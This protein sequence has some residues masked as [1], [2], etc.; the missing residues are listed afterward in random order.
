M[1]YELTVVGGDELCQRG[2]E[3]MIS[4]RHP[5]ILQCSTF[6]SCLAFSSVVSRATSSLFIVLPIKNRYSYYYKYN[7]CG[8][9][10]ACIVIV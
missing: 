3:K 1:S 4:D 8:F 10:G 9:D 6:S 2:T 5:A 7:Y